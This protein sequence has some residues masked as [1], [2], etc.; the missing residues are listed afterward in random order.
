M[1][2][3]RPKPMAQSFAQAIKELQ[4]PD[5][6][7]SGIQARQAVLLKEHAEWLQTHDRAMAEIRENG[8]RIDERIEKT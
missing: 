8:R 7:M 2:K 3:D 6:V 1:L 5:I 4:E